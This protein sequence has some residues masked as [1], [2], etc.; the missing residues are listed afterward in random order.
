M[1]DKIV[2]KQMPLSLAENIF[3]KSQGRFPCRQDMRE[4]A[5]I[6]RLSP[7]QPRVGGMVSKCRNYILNYQPLNAIQTAVPHNLTSKELL[8]N[9]RKI[10]IELHA[11]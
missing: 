10:F 2:E 6:Q 9:I 7:N 5:M 4:G 8:A 3:E 1:G 11:V